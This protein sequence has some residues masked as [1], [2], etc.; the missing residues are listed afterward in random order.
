MILAVVCYFYVTIVYDILKIL[1]RFFDNDSVTIQYK[2][3]KSNEPL[4]SFKIKKG[5]R[6]ILFNIFIA[7]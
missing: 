4:D 7:P 5:K 2:V 6:E 3:Y 1:Q